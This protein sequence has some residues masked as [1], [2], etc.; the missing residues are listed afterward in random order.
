MNKVPDI[1][2]I[3]RNILPLSIR[4]FIGRVLSIPKYMS[5]LIN[6]LLN[7]KKEFQY[8][9]SIAAIAKSEA[10]YIREWIEYHIIVGVEHFYIYDNESPDNLKTVLQPLID[11]GIVT[12]TFSPGKLKQQ[13][14]YNDAIKRFRNKSKWMAFI[15]IDEF[16]VPLKR[17]KIT[18]V[19]ND[20][21]SLFKKRLFI[22]LKI[23]WVLY[24]YSGHKTMPLWGGGGVL[25]NYTRHNGVD[26]QIKSIVNPRTVV[27]YHIHHGDH[28][29]GLKGIN[30]NG[31]EIE[32]YFIDDIKNAGVEH[33]RINHYFTKSYEEFIR[34]IER[35]FAD[36][37]GR[38]NLPIFDPGYLSDNE[39]K[40]MEKYVSLIKPKLEEG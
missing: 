10:F 4:R 31:V 32:G 8:E 14:A 34:K 2:R 13:P 29:F 37:E 30:E 12:Y 35:G 22:C 21:N 26:K 11:K 16:I 19:I 25:E 23:H 39:D 7:N 38:Y 40:I 24:G 20:I 1:K 9:L 27:K 28:L 33:I 6:Y 15:D 3:Y 36:K 17:D 5:V 18:D